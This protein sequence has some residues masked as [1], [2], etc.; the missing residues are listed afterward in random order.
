[1]QGLPWWPVVKTLP[2]NA[3]GTGLIHGWEPKI[4]NA[5]WPK[6]QNI[7]SI[8][9]NSIKTLKMV[10]IKKKKKERNLKEK[11]D[12]IQIEFCVNSCDGHQSY[13]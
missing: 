11:N 5:S 4:P 12:T 3:G 9:T 1:M 8:V 13:S 2:C 10:H 7:N 6:N